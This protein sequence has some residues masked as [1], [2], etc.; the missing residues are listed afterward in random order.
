MCEHDHEGRA[1]RTREDGNGVTRRRLLG[2]LG[3][4]GAVA[5]AGCSRNYTVSSPDA[6]VEP[7]WRVDV[8]GA[9][10]TGPPTSTGDRLY[11]GAQ[12]KA[13][14]GFSLDDGTE[15]LRFETG[16]PIEALPAVGEDGTVHVHST[17]GDLYGVDATGDL[18]W[19]DEGLDE[20]GVVGRVGSL[21][22]E[23]GGAFDTRMMRGV[24]A[25]TGERLFERRV[26][27][28]RLDGLADDRVVV[29]VPTEDD[30]GRVVSLGTDGGVQWRGEPTTHYPGLVVDSDLV[31]AGPGSPLVGYDPSDGRVRWRT[32]VGSLEG[33]APLVLGSQVY[34]PRSGGGGG[35]ADEVV[36]LD[37]TSGEVVWRANAGGD[38]RSLVATDDAVFVGS[39]ADDPEGGSLGRVDCIESDGTRR[40]RTTTTVLPTVDRL[41]RLGDHVLAASRRALVALTQDAGA[42]Q[43]QYEPGSYSRVRVATVG[44]SVFVSHVDEGVVARLPTR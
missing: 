43:W 19:A 20:W 23:L 39:I 31:V 26:E 38:L 28:F 5:L 44:E 2:G 22:V 8:E 34:A 42:T 41:H 16:G 27:T 18:L 4:A 25:A 33:S 10:K 7:V 6:S 15:T 36:A 9:S 32:N 11:V 1:D 37:R 29:Q 30:G 40:W 3:V 14:H 12:D 13:L 21:V 24:D 17:D 35:R